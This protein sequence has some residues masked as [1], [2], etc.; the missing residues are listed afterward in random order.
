MD[1]NK[2]FAG[3]KVIQDLS[4]QMKDVADTN[5]AMRN[6]LVNLEGKLCEKESKTNGRFEA[7]NEQMERVNELMKEQNQAI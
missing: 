4:R 6:F 1:I 3:T 2:A 7:L 5:K